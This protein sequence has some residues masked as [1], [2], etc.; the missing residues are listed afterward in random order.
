MDCS[1]FLLRRMDIVPFAQGT[2]KKQ[3]QDGA[4][5]LCFLLHREALDQTRQDYMMIT[6]GSPCDIYLYP[7]FRCRI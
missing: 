2:K 6:L 1:T 5:E 4:D 7:L 3:E